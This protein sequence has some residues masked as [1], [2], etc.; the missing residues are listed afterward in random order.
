MAGEVVWKLFIRTNFETTMVLVLTETELTQE[1][2]VASVSSKLTC[3]CAGSP[4]SLPPA[5]GHWTATLEIDPTTFFVAQ[6]SS[7]CS[8]SSNI[9]RWGSCELRLYPCW[10]DPSSHLK[11][12]MQQ[13]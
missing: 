1:S 12:S 7:Q 8:M 11:I 6:L 10:L 13:G 9:Q 2:T 3:V 5:G 4:N